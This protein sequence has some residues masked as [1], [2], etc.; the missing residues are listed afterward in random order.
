V[1][2][3][4]QIT[5]VELLLI[6]RS[7]LT[8]I[9]AIFF[10]LLGI[11]LATQIRSFPIGPVGI[12][13]TAVTSSMSFW[14]ILTF[15]TLGQALRKRDKQVG[16]MIWATVSPSWAYIWGKFL[17]VFCMSVLFSL[18]FELAAIV[19]DQFWNIHV[20]LPLIQETT[21][22]PLGWTAFLVFWLLFVIIPVLFGVALAIGSNYL[23]RN[24]RLIGYAVTLICWAFGMRA[25]LPSWMDITSMKALLNNDPTED[26]GSLVFNNMQHGLSL[27]QATHIMDMVRAEIP[28]HFLDWTFAVNRLFFALL[29]LLLI[30]L[31]VLVVNRRRCTTGG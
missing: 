10:I 6:A 11:W 16:K 12:Y 9:L 28:P 1:K 22:P 5:K 17:G 19:A 25:Y 18:I 26:F 2:T 15:W 3:L 20:S 8:Y 27:R 4:F 23:T 7:K 13:Y 24:G 21:Y 31:T 14:L 30:W 29:S